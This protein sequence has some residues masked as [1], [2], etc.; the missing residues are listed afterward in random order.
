[1][2]LT[3]AQTALLNEVVSGEDRVDEAFKPA[4]KLVDLG[5]CTWALPWTGDKRNRLIPTPAGRQAL[6][7]GERG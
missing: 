7:E 1:M 3:F 4:I 6:R 2:K 5:L